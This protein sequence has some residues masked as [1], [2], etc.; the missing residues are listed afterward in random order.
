MR[1][2]SLPPRTLILP[3][4]VFPCRSSTGDPPAPSFTSS[5]TYQAATQ[6]ILNAAA[7]VAPAGALDAARPPGPRSRATARSDPAGS[8]FHPVWTEAGGHAEIC[9]PA[10][11]ARLT[12]VPQ[13]MDHPPPKIR[14]RARRFP[15]RRWVDQVAIFFSGRATRPAPARLGALYLLAPLPRVAGKLA[16]EAGAALATAPISRLWSSCGWRADIFRETLRLYPSGCDDGARN[17]PGAQRCIR[18][19]RP[20][21]TGR[22]VQSSLALATSRHERLW[23]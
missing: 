11:P 8:S 14:R 3:H 7:F 15:P 12:G 21:P 13:I 1:Y 2:M 6:P 19:D 5:A 10:P 23:D 4:A 17:R 16:A 20:V 18:G 9:R 22:A